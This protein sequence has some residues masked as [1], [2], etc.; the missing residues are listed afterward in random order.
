ML[1]AYTHATGRGLYEY[2]S[3]GGPGVHAEYYID[4][5]GSRPAGEVWGRG[6]EQLAERYGLELSKGLDRETFNR[7]AAGVAP[8]GSRRLVQTQHGKHKPGHDLNFSPPKSV[9]V[10]RALADDPAD[11]AAI[12]EASH[13]AMLKSLAFLQDNARVCRPTVDG[14]TKRVTADLVIGVFSHDCA[15]PTTE[16]IVRGSPP[17][18]QLHDHAF[19]FNL[20]LWEGRVLSVDNHGIHQVIRTAEAIYQNELAHGLEQAGYELRYFQGKDG[21]RSFELAGFDHQVLGFFSTRSREVQ[22]RVWQFEERYGRPP[23]EREMTDLVRSSRLAKETGH[24][25]EPEWHEYGEALD[26]AGL[27]RPVP[28]PH[29][30]ATYE[31]PLAEREEEVRQALLAPD[32]LTRDDAACYRYQIRERLYNAAI[33]RLTPEEAEAYLARFIDSPDLKLVDRAAFDPDKDL[34]TT[35]A[36]LERERWVL[37]TAIAKHDTPASAPIPEAIER[38]IAAA[39]VDLDDEQ[40]AAV[41]ALCEPAAW[42]PTLVGWAGTG[43]TTTARAVLSAYEDREGVERPAADEVIV[44]AVAGSTAERTAE[45]LGVEK[46]MTVESFANAVERWQLH[47]TDRTLIVVDEA[48]ML[49]TPRYQRLLEAASPAIVRQLGDP[50]QLEA[51][52]AGGLTA[53]ITERVGSVELTQVH[54]QRDPLDVEA[55]KL[56][57]LG[58][59]ER[60][61]EGF[62]SRGRIHVD[63]TRGESVGRVLKDYASHRDAGRTADEVIINTDVSNLQIDQL[64]RLVQN[65]RLE[66]GELTGD[67]ILIEDRYNRREERLHVGDLV[68]FTEPYTDAWTRLKVRNG[69]AGT[70]TRVDPDGRQVHVRIATSGQPYGRV[71]RVELD[72]ARESQPLRLAYAGHATRV[73][74]GEAPVNLVLPNSSSSRNSG[75]SMMTRGQDEIHVYLN[76]ETHGLHRATP[77]EHLARSWAAPEHKRTATELLADRERAADQAPDREPGEHVSVAQG[78]ELDRSTA[79]EAEAPAAEADPGAELDP[80]AVWE[81]EYSSPEVAAFLHG[82]EANR[83]AFFGRRDDTNR[84]RFFDRDDLDRDAWRKEVGANRERF[85]S[86]EP[87]QAREQEL[88][89]GLEIEW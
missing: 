26:R 1:K 7:L 33:G 27:A 79:V 50:E 3:H 20:G 76:H 43:K 63:E 81:P 86:R 5:D 73:Q 25:R 54:R 65:W 12:R 21:R 28:Q 22:A 72:E 51:I 61:L 6:A 23:T 10:A 59:A 71:V 52:G 83:E 62:A 38:A 48:Y 57:R 47:V 53:Q 58:E 84:E 89:R 16:T 9:S 87:E 78:K 19:V 41:R 44:V 49:D 8:D 45:K 34:F 67:A 4:G 55:L 11:R 30:G 37:A 15:R 70:V 14:Q 75:Y 68:S 80:A 40:V 66:R 69:M 88:D 29:R 17:D 74:G 18:P 85:F 32:G 82:S 60:A 35:V 36:N 2:L 46:A 39:N 56:L 24:E 31:R 13:R 77:L 64:N 42:A